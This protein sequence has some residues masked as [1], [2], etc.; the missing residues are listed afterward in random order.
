MGVKSWAIKKKKKAIVLLIQYHDASEKSMA[1]VL[2]NNLIM[3][4]IQLS[5]I[6]PLIHWYKLVEQS[7]VK[8]IEV[9]S[10]VS[11]KSQY[12]QCNSCY[13]D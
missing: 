11:P 8:G 3:T 10:L 2:F 12:N 13:M 9:L 5:S 7:K 1:I 6:P 4:S